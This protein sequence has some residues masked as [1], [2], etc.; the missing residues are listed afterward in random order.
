[1]TAPT[2]RTQGQ[3]VGPRL[4]GPDVVR[5]IALIGVVVM[6]FHGYLIIRSERGDD[7]VGT[8]W[9]AELFDPWDGPLTTR[10]AATFVLVAGVGVTL[11]TR[12][13]VD[14]RSIG[15]AVADQGTGDETAGETAGETTGET[16]TETAGNA[17]VTALRLRLVRRGLLLYVVGLLLDE[18]WPGTIIVYYGAMFVLAAALITLR[19]RWIALVGIAAALAGAGISTWQYERNLDFTSTSWLSDPEVGSL[20][21]HLFGLFVN[22]THPLLPWFAFLCAG[23]LLGRFLHAA[24]WRMVTIGIAAGLIGLSALASTTATTTLQEQLS[25]IHP[26]DRGLAYTASALGT[27]LLAY[28]TIDWIAVR[29]PVATDPLRRAGQM[30]LTLY[31]AHVFVFNLVVDWFGW[32]EPAGLDVAL[33]FALLFWVVGITAAVTWQRRYGIGPAERVYR[34]VGG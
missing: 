27:A 34:A 9:A 21:D 8:G 2:I 29:F 24:N 6:N 14:Q 15:H 3:R 5:A 22:G 13:A 11:M 17:P 19:S 26:L 32:I 30:T 12:R 4:P 25:S 1:V 31:L 10:F 28:A 7:A 20:R 33:A 16:A 18:I 23:M